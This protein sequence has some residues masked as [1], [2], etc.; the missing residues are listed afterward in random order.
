MPDGASDAELGGV[1]SRRWEKGEAGANRLQAAP[2]QEPKFQE[3][4]RV[5]CFHGPLLREAKCMKV[6]IKD[7]QAT[8]FIRYDGWNKN[9]DERVPESGALKHVDSSRQ[10]QQEQEWCAEGRREALPRG[11]RWP[12]CGRK[13]MK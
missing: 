12:A 10:K 5:L 8:C 1:E 7:R 2:K 4:E 6:A 13:A 9:W 11:G 3:G